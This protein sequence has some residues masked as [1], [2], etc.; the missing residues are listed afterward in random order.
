MFDQ[1]LA[2]L[3]EVAD[4]YGEDEPADDDAPQA[5]TDNQT[6]ATDEAAKRPNQEFA[7]LGQTP[8]VQRVVHIPKS[9]PKIDTNDANDANATA[10]AASLTPYLLSTARRARSRTQDLTL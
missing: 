8:I 6:S 1:L 4:P 9:A 2:S 3:T 10:P 7:A 5:R